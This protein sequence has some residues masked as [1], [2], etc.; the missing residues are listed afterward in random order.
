MSHMCRTM[1]A[2]RAALSE[3]LH[4]AVRESRLKSRLGEQC[5][6]VCSL[7]VLGLLQIYSGGSVGGAALMNEEK[8]DICLNWAGDLPH[9]SVHIHAMAAG[10]MRLCKMLLYNT[11]AADV[12]I[13]G[14]KSPSMLAGG[15]Q[16]TCPL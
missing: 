6:G 5:G 14:V 2:F 1:L 8:T 7:T 10:A 15:K 12:K 11:G 3:T 16:A 9:W 4:A 13:L